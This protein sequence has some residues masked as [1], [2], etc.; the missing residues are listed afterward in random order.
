MDV[1]APPFDDNERAVHPVLVCAARELA[2]LRRLP[3]SDQSEVNARREQAEWVLERVLPLANACTRAEP[4]REVIANLVDQSDAALGAII[5]PER[6]IRVVVEPSGWNS[7]PAREAVR[8]SHR[9]VLTAMQSTRKPLLTKAVADSD[10]KPSDYELFAAPILER[11]DYASGY[12]LLVKS[13]IA[14]DFGARQ[15]K[16]LERTVPLVQMLI[17]RDFDSM[18]DLRSIASLERAVRE[19]QRTSD[20]SAMRVVFV[21]IRGLAGINASLG[22]DS[23]DRV[24]R[25]VAKMLRPP[26]VPE[27]SLRA[28][29][30]GG[31][32]A[33]LLTRCDDEDAE[34][35]ATKIREAASRVLISREA[36]QPGVE[37]VTGIAEV[38]PVA[39]GLR[40]ALVA[41]R[42]AA[43]AA[44]AP[45]AEHEPRREHSGAAE[46]AVTIEDADS[47][48]PDPAAA[49]LDQAFATFAAAAPPRLSPIVLREALR[50][51]RLHLFAQPMRPVR[52]ARKPVRVELLPRI[53]DARGQVI[54]ARDFLAAGPDP[55]AL[56]ELDRWVMETALQVIEGR[57]ERLG[58]RP[59]EFTMN[60]SGRSLE[61]GEFHAFVLEAL[62]SSDALAER[63][64]FEVAEETAF[65]QQRDLEK[66]ARRIMA[67]GARLA[68]DNVGSAHGVRLKTHCAS[69]IKVDGQLIRDVAS[70]P[71]AQ[72]LVETLA[73]WA[74]ASRMDTVAGQVESEIVRAR[75]ADFGIDYA[76]G[77][78]LDEPAPFEE[79]LD[80]IISPQALRKSGT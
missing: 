23:A 34:R 39:A 27:E 61:S 18:T 70:D 53:V 48:G 79:V 55:D 74:G 78:A 7:E 65:R 54:T 19:R 50:E 46:P 22:P 30:G 80:E 29:I 63:W 41:A 43:R 14:G 28:R 16:L 71:R 77:F 68:L 25:R 52:D 75:L 5:V 36:S 42:A 67:T 21:D 44:I 31:H 8:R 24:I 33:V 56:Y 17:D 10:G 11:A 32:F 49:A 3:N 66:F 62:R 6:A 59:I 37:L 51:N 73:Q 76:Q 57:R 58:D 1:L 40:H 13:G 20:T 69:S 4:L 72:R 2:T 35:V 26:V 15:Q 38:K 64:L 60:V 47:G 45:D 12:V 9:K